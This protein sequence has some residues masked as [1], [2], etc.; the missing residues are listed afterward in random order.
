MRRI[1][2]HDHCAMA[3]PRQLKPSSC[4]QTGLPYPSLTTEQ[5]NAHGDSLAVALAF[6][7]DLEATREI[8]ACFPCILMRIPKGVRYKSL[9]KTLKGRIFA[10]PLTF[11]PN[12]RPFA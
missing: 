8:P 2:T 3:N 11:S 1:N 4:R 9:H 10:A 12:S 6:R 7:V 5:K